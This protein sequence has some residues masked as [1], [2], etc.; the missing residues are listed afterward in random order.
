[1]NLLALVHQ[2]IS[3]A[4]TTVDYCAHPATSFTD[5]GKVDVSPTY[6]HRF[7]CQ[8]PRDKAVW[9]YEGVVTVL[10]SKSTPRINA[11]VANGTFLVIF[12]FD[13]EHSIEGCIS[14]SADVSV[15]RP[16]SSGIS[17]ELKC[18]DISNSISISVIV[19]GKILV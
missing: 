11:T 7:S 8:L 14:V 15:I 17:F 3:A 10:H 5:I 18:E 6:P 16:N 2:L 19:E 1:M 4:S 13:T 12:N 9:K